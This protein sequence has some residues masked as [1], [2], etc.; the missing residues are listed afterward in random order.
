MEGVREMR[1]W[2]LHNFYLTLEGRE[3]LKKRSGCQ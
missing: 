1:V 3:N 2:G